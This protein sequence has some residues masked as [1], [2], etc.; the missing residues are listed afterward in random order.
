MSTG[1]GR[2]GSAVNAVNGVL[3][4]SG[5]AEWCHLAAPVHTGEAAR[6]KSLIPADNVYNPC[7]Y[8]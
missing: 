8:T 2:P 7:I 5:G 3:N 6:G 1:N 4:W